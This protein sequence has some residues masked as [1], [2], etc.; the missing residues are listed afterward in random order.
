MHRRTRWNIISAPSPGQA[1][2]LL[3][4]LLTMHL[5]AGDAVSGVSAYRITSPD[6]LFS[7]TYADGQLHDYMLE[8]DRIAVLIS[9]IGHTE[10]NALSGGNLLDAGSSDDRVDTVAEFYTY[11]DDDW[12]RQAVYTSIT[13]IDDGSGGGP[14]AIRVTGTDSQDSALT[15]VTIYSLGDGDAALRVT[16]SLQNTGGTHYANFELGDAFNWGECRKWAPGFGFAVSGTTSEAWLAGAAAVSYGYVSPL[17][18]VWGPHGS[19]WSDLNCVAV[20]LGPGDDAEYSRHFVV[21]AADVASVATVIH[22]TI[23]APVGALRCTV[24]S[25]ASGD[26]LPS[27]TIDAFDDSELVY[28]Q[29]LTN[30]SG[31][32]ATTLPPGSWRLVTSASGHL[33]DET[34]ISSVEDDTTFVEIALDIDGEIPAIGDTLTILRRPL[35]NIPAIVSPGDTLRIDCAANP[36]TAGWMAELRYASLALPMTVLSAV[37]NPGTTWW[38]LDVLIPDVPLYELYDLHVSADGEIDDLSWNAV[39]VIPAVKDDYY[40]IHITDTHLPTHLYVDDPASETDSTSMIDL[41]EV[42]GDIN[43]I[44]PEFVLLTGDLVN[45]GELEDYLYRRYYTRSQRLLAELQVPVYLTAG[46]HDL[47]GWVQTPPPAGTARRDWW[48]FYGWPR[49]DDPPADA[50]W[51]T[52]DYSFD[53]GPVHFVGLEAYDNYDLWREE[54]YGETSFISSQLQWLQDDLN[55]ATGSTSR[56][57]FYHYD[58]KHELNLNALGVDMALWG[59]I[60]GNSGDIHAH[61]YDLGTD[62]TSRGNRAYRLVRVSGGVLTPTATVWAGSAGEKL[63]AEFTPANDGSHDEVTAQVTNELGEAFE[64]SRL[65]FLMPNTG[66]DIVVDGGTLQQ[67]HEMDSLLVCYV[68]VEIAPHSSQMVTVSLGPTAIAAGE[69][70]PLALGHVESLPNPF[71]SATTLRY[72]LPRTQR[73]RLAVYDAT[74]RELAVLAE[75]VEQAGEH[76][77]RWAGRDDTGRALPSGVYFSRLEAA[78]R[79]ITRKLVLTR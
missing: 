7:G 37:Y 13:I 17:G 16:T 39:R 56:V 66:A 42:I 11:F 38:Q 29:M 10:Y 75:E 6:S 79:T 21:G 8:N 69:D 46:N 24:T 25:A 67:V 47:G 35:L 48:R 53:Y 41:R 49:L 73:I 4:T 23:G 68:G 19:Y 33:P 22:E 26:P 44:N 32:G 57:L 31:L 50:P 43:L 59:H 18:E 60:H 15:V 14:A 63:R 52:Q 27:A 36:G 55:A 12:P 2:L 34:W 28:L 20:D 3:S 78:G 72:S 74:G 64:H 71:S 54:I 1:V 40:F 62:N 76:V 45:E 61:P 70:S 51:R 30:L 5:A 65:R 58:F 77:V 9:D